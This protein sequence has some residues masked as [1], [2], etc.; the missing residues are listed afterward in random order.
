MSLDKQH[1]TF[2]YTDEQ[3]IGRFQSGDELAFSVTPTKDCYV[4]VFNLMADQ[5]VML[6]FPN[7]FLKE[8]YV[9][10]KST[11]QIPDPEIRRYIKF[12]VSPMPGEEITSENIYIVCIFLHRC[13][14][15][16]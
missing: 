9:K 8:N 14:L 2:V 3:L 15:K 16:L 1:S 11:L 6:M 10:G 13:F 7:E 12:R 4:Y 5:N